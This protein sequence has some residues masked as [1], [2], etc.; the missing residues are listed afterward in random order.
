MKST[1]S[2][3]IPT[4]LMLIACTKAESFTDTP[5]PAEAAQKEVDSLFSDLPSLARYLGDSSLYHF[6]EKYKWQSAYDNDYLI[7]FSGD[8]LYQ[9]IDR[10]QQDWIFGRRRNIEGEWEQYL[11]SKRYNF[12]PSYHYSGEWLVLSNGDSYSL[13][14]PTL[15]RN[16]SFSFELKAISKR[17]V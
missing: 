13:S 11:S 3:L 7:S 6:L 14:A 1:A 4:I 15:Y 9:E 16:Q 17:I 5:P 12:S 10:R 8:T 2:L